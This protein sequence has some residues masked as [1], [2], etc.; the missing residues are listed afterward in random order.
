M[1]NPIKISLK[2]LETYRNQGL[3]I[4]SG[5]YLRFYCPIH[6]SDHQRSLS[7]NSETGYFKCFAC[8]A[9][10]YVEDFLKN[11]SIKAHRPL[12]NRV[13]VKYTVDKKNPILERFR[14]YRSYRNN[15]DL[16]SLLKTFQ[17]ALP[18]SLGEKY[19][20]RRGIPLEVAQK[21]GVGYAPPGTWPNRDWKYGRVV[22]P[23][24]DAD[25]KVIN[26]YGRAVEITEV[27]KD[28]KHDHLWGAKG[29]FNSKELYTDVVFICEGVFDALSLIVA[30]YNA[31]AIFGVSGLN[32]EWVK[33]KKIIFAFDKDK[34]GEKWKDFAWEAILL[35]KE[36]Y[37]LSEETYA[38]Y[39]DLNE[40]WIATG[41]I[42]IGKWEELN[43]Q[44]DTSVEERE[45]VSEVSEVSEPLSQETDNQF[46]YE[47]FE[48]NISFY[49]NMLKARREMQED[50]NTLAFTTK[51]LEALKHL[52]NEDKDY[53]N[54][55][56][57]IKKIFQGTIV[58]P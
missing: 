10:G 25:G 43:S 4:R 17:R 8:G 15:Y 24:T 3:G 6:G 16:E 33:S 32:W 40:V 19:L 9:W 13:G 1:N 12:E 28:L 39:K 20:Q 44:N 46:L 53:V 47:V 29:V 22:F 23:H 36:V 27:P 31:V 14:G 58:C 30:G 49:P 57:M 18:G 41:K 54:K 5:K 7:V 2:D 51:E 56:L 26:L 11:D 48:G 34:A 42:D 55:I 52:K 50:R 38:G 37:Y 35:G 45:E 21:F